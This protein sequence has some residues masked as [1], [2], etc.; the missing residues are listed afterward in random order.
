EVHVWKRLRHRNILPLIGICHLDSVT[1]MVSPW[2]VNGNAFDYLKRVPKASRL[3]LLAQVASGLEYLHAFRPTVV[4][5]D[6]RSVSHN[7]L[8]SSTGDACIADF[9]LS[10]VVEEVSKYSQST[11]WKNAGNWSFMAPELFGE[12]PPPRSVETDVFSFGR[13]IF[14]VDSVPYARISLSS[15]C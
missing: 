12:N 10:E 1:Y 15:K 13:V 2:M 7:I 8:I 9:G 6:L 3:R 11:S 14:E 5:G 4:H